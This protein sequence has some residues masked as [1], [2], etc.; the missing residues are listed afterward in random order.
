MA[1]GS[2]GFLYRQPDLAVEEEVRNLSSQFVVLYDRFA[3]RKRWMQTAENHDPTAMGDEIPATAC[4]GW[5]SSRKP[6]RGADI[7]VIAASTGGPVALEKVCVGLPASLEAPVLVVQHMP[8]DF[9][10]I[11]A[12]ALDLQAPLPVRE[13]FEG[14]PIRKGE[15]VIAPGGFHMTAVKAGG[16]L[17]VLMNT[18]PPVNGVRPAAD[19]LFGSVAETY[20]GA[21]VLAVVLTGM[22]NDG[23][24]GVRMLKRHC[25]CYCLVQSE[26]T[27]AVYGMP[28]SVYEA[29]LA[30][31]VLDIDSM[32]KRME[33]LVTG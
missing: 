22:G 2:T 32:A 6:L 26:K 28:R 4:H 1:A 20:R 13:G 33:Q 12:E 31:E 25:D 19:I 23:M 7:V 11:M 5:S 3:T 15:V 9:T 10:R 29:G 21:K 16:V 18:A 30:D 8:R 24:K 14:M 27:C 17:Q